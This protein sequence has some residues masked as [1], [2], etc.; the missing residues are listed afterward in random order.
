MD[1]RRL[2]AFTA[3]LLIAAC[4]NLGTQKPAPVITYG[5]GSGGGSAGVHNVMAGDTLY[6]VASAYRL[7]MRDIVLLNNIKAPFKLRDGQRLKLPP[8]QEYRARAGDTIYDVSR[9]FGV[10]SSEI[11]RLNRI[12]P[13]Y[14]LQSGQTLRLPSATRKTQI[15]QK[16]KTEFVS[17]GQGTPRYVFSKSGIERK[18]LDA[19]KATAQNTMNQNTFNQGAINQADADI[20][21]HASAVDAPPLPQPEDTGGVRTVSKFTGKIP[22]R[23]SDKFLR[24]VN[25]KVISD[26]GPKKTGEHND[27]I[28][29][30]ADKGTPIKA[31]ENGVVVYAGNE[32]K[33][34]GNLVLVRHEGQWVTAYAHMDKIGVRKGDKVE[35]GQVIGAVGSTGSV[36]SPQLHFEIRRGT[37]AINPKNYLEK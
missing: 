16:R 20:L 4:V 37:D 5:Q 1:L 11:A 25:G 3:V 10:N 21:A 8:P 14:S 9:L 31:A 28:N 23:V 34:S 7:P 12:G 33:L 36:D 13:P 29:I 30:S 26:F 15:A 24:P 27:G 6:T 22:P 17:A 32:L 18:V 2:F 19:P 35:R